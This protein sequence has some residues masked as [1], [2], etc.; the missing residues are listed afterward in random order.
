MYLHHQQPRAT[1]AS[2][3][4]TNDDHD[5]L[6]DLA[7]VDDA[8]KLGEH[9]IADVALLADHLLVLVVRVVRVAQLAVRVELELKELMTEHTP[10]TH[11]VRQSPRISIQPSSH[12]SMSELVS[13]KRDSE[14]YRLL[15][16]SLSQ[17]S[18]ATT[19]Y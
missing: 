7:V 5:V 9:R 14:V 10:V 18:G 3:V 11:T 19:T 13:E 16:P 15:L 4:L 12:P 2:I 17:P 1:S 6:G 8:T